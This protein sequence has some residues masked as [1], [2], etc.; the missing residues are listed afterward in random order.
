MEDKPD[1]ILR[2]EVAP[3]RSPDLQNVGEAL[4]AWN[5]VIK[6]AAQLIDPSAE[7][8]VELAGVEP[9]SQLF[10][11]V[12]RRVEEFAQTLKAGA[13]QYPLTAKTALALALMIGSSV[14][15]AVIQDSL[16][17]SPQIPEE[18]MGVFR[19]IERNLKESVE[20]QRNA[21]RFYGILGHDPA[22]TGVELLDGTDRHVIWSVPREQFAERSGFWGGEQP[23]IYEPKNRIAR[24]DVTLI[25]AAFVPKPRRWTFARD[26]LEFGATMV[27]PQVL[28]AIAEDR[29]PI[30]IAEGVR[31]EVEVTYREIYDGKSWVPDAASRRITK[32]L[33]PRLPAPSAPLFP[34]TGP[35]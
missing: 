19:G 2:L 14:A 25:R 22:I 34:D 5:D 35:P 11:I 4:I 13:D 10:K 32:V 27:D 16:T 26:G 9:G 3:E 23:L 29:L 31:M 24:W 17:E 28:S 7:A 20:L 8:K 1:L 18:Q 12:L 6:T 33:K 15:G 30:R 21:Q